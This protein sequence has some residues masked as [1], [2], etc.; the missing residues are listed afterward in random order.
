VARGSSLY[1]AKRCGGLR[2]GSVAVA[3]AI[4]VAALTSGIAGFA[5]SGIC[6]ALLFHIMHGPI[7]IVRLMMICSIANQTMGVWAVRRAVHWSSLRPFL[8]GGAVGVPLG[9][10]LL[11]HADPRLYEGAIGLML[12]AYCTWMLF[13]KPI[14]ARQTTTLGDLLVGSVAGVAGGFAGLAGV[15]TAIRVA[16]KGWDK[17]R[18]RALFQPLILI[19]QVLALA[20]VQGGRPLWTDG[21]GLAAQAL[22]YLHGSLLGTWWGLTILSDKQFAMSRNLLLI[23]SGITL[24][25]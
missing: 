3:L 17:D 14:V 22:Y 25:L 12:I 20:L 13:R 7:Q 8:L 19:S 11:T 15:P 16:M 9:V 23:L 18:Q 21:A 6:G 1:V 24:A 10:Y 4:L 5:F 2:H